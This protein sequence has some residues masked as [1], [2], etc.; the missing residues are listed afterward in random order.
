MEYK[1]FYEETS[2]AGETKIIMEVKHLFL[3]NLGIRLCIY[4]YNNFM[5][6][7]WVFHGYLSGRGIGGNQEPMLGTHTSALNKR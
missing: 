7:S 5:G 1:S 2:V 3:R 4:G 6:I